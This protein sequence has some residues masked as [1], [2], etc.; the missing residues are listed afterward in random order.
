MRLQHCSSDISHSQCP[1]SFP[2][3]C[4][5]MGVP[6]R[7]S[8]C[9]LKAASFILIVYVTAGSC[10]ITRLP[11][12][13]LEFMAMRGSH[14]AVL[15][16]R[17]DVQLLGNFLRNSTIPVTL[18]PCL[19][20]MKCYRSLGAFV[21]KDGPF[22]RQQ[23]AFLPFYRPLP[24]IFFSEVMRF[25]KYY[26]N[27]QWILLVKKHEEVLDRL[28]NYSCQ[29]MTVNEREINVPSNQYKS[30]GDRRLLTNVGPLMEEQLPPRGSYPRSNELYYASGDGEGECYDPR[31]YITERILIEFYGALNNSMIRLCNHNGD[32][33]SLLLDRKVDLL[34]SY[35][36]VNCSA[37]CFYYAH[38]TFPPKNAC[39]FVR[40]RKSVEPSFANT[41]TSFFTALLALLPFATIVI[42]FIRLVCSTRSD[43][44]GSIGIAALSLVS[45]NFAHSIPPGVTLSS[46][47][48]KLAFGAWIIG[49]FFLLNVVQTQLTASRSFPAYTPSIKTAEQLEALLDDGMIVPCLSLFMANTIQKTTAN[50]TYLATLKRSILNCKENC[51][52][53]EPQKECFERSRK[54]THT[55]I[56]SCLNHVGVRAKKFGIVPGED[57]LFM[58]LG[59][60]ETHGRFPLR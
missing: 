28:R 51:V 31:N 56:T 39:F 14:A 2:W 24:R 20:E 15:S 19:E 43:K 44:N 27:L 54:G 30:C 16:T 23:V 47:S 53:E 4:D 17:A 55:T 9:F 36:P 18:W 41:W 52:I 57:T 13:A 42:I 34:V 3:A 21:A 58:I 11:L 35:N 40:R 59:S 6:G 48:S 37:P 26:A 8:V 50:T 10:N 49:M 38:A 7:S 22:S 12:E 1:R 25:Q 33:D 32:S 60:S 5:I 45:A 46:V 29:V